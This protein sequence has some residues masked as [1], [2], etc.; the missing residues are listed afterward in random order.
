LDAR[1]K[2]RSVSF[3]R[4]AVEVADGLFVAAYKKQHKS[5]TLRFREKCETA[6]VKAIFNN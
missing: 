3:P 5:I 4:A 1:L 2:A 6:L